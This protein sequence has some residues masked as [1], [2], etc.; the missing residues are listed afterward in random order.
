MK[1]EKK[2]VKIVHCLSGG[3]FI[4]SFGLIVLHL[5][6]HFMA[7]TE[8]SS[9]SLRT[10]AMISE[11]AEE[12]EKVENGFEINP[13]LEGLKE[14]NPDVIG[15]IEIPDTNIDYPVM[16]G[17]DNQYY[18]DHTIYGT[19]NVAGSIFMEVQNQDDFSDLVTFLY[20]HRM[21]DGSMF[22]N[23]K[24]YESEEY[25]KSHPE[26]YVSTCREELI[27]DIFSVHRAALGD[28]TYT[29]FFEAGE[30]YEKYLQ[31]EKEKSWYDTGIEVGRDDQ[32]LVLV[33]CTADQKD[34][35]IV[36][37]GKRR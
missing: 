20:G 14:I 4:L 24:F 15:W 21:R 16:Q 7:R 35:R 10:A 29:L 32:I 28:A 2:S 9:L 6:G 31:D 17:D 11:A 37:L 13:K 3:I 1:K 36:V 25:W 8:Y 19:D 27:Y 30:G 26:I 34:E 22:G 23:L 5:C 12:T 33:T 18:M